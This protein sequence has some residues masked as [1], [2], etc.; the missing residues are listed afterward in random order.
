MESI[1]RKEVGKFCATP[2]KIIR[3]GSGAY[4]YKKNNCKLGDYYN[5]KRTTETKKDTVYRAG[6]LFK[7]KF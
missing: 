2:S 4:L 7:I 6:N 3:D 1:T 5:G